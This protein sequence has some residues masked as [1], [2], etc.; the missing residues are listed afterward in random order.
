[1]EVGRL[2]TAGLD[3][4][5][6]IDEDRKCMI[7]DIEKIDIEFRQHKGIVQTPMGDY[8]VTHPQVYVLAINRDNDA[9]LH[10]GYLGTHD[11]A[12]FNS[13]LQLAALPQGLQ[14]EIVAKVKEKA[15]RDMKVCITPAE[16]LVEDA[17]D[18]DYDNTDDE[19]TE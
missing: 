11:G 6:V 15:G 1:V 4:C 9:I 8:E 14:D 2:D 18:D 17:D 5:N 13:T 3:R 16:T 10:V 7:I 19:D 12:P